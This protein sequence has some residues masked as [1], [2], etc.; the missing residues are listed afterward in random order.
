M[1]R[2]VFIFLLMAPVLFVHTAKSQKVYPISSWESLFQWA[3]VEHTGYSTNP[4]L[5]YTFFFNI[6]QYWHADLNNNI[7]IFSGLAVR[8][9]GFI[10]D[11]DIPTKT[12]RR[13]YNLGVPLAI[14]LGVFDKHLYIFGGGEYELLLHYKGKRW[15]S[16]DRDGTKYKDTGWFSSKTERFIPSWFVGV[17]FPGGFNLK[18]KQYIGDFLNLDYVGNDLGNPSVHFSDYTRLTVHYI[19]LSWQIRT[20]KVKDYMPTERVAYNY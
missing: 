13:S 1:K 15:D 10:Y 16:N 6:G 17:Q 9:V 8:N 11:T 19:S 14:K 2:F 20:D 12:I 18:Y 3:D 4:R 5:R 7:G